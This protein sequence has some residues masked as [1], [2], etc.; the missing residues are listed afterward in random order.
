MI[1]SAEKLR[2]TSSGVVVPSPNTISGYGTIPLGGIIMWSGSSVPDGWA[3]C[4]GQNGTPDLRNRFIV[5]SGGE[6]TTGNTEPSHSGGDL[7]GNWGLVMTPSYSHYKRFTWRDRHHDYWVYRGLH[8]GLPDLEAGTYNETNGIFVALSNA[9][10]VADQSFRFTLH[11]SRQDEFLALTS[12]NLPGWLG[13]DGL[14]LQGAPTTNDMATNLL[15]L[16]VE[17]LYDHSRVTNTLTLAAV[18][19]GSVQT[20][21]ALALCS[22]NSYTD[23][24]VI[25]SNRPP[26]LAT[27][28]APSNS[29]T[30]RYYYKTEP[31]FHWPGVATPPP[32]GSIVPYLRPVDA[33]T[34]E[35]AGDPDSKS[36]E[37]LEIVYRPV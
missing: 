34:G 33:D 9:T 20:Q 25:F 14:A 4:N 13:I 23:T 11:A 1:G 15:Q 24:I 21:P 8:A 28:P 6:Y 18:N 12:T 35:F 22:T 32:T 27:S 2:I 31:S 26:F 37:S 19:S 36:T 7:P 30:M 16:V 3:L 5:G 29:F 10:A 17:D